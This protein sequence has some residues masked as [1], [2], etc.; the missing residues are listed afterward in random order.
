MT[1]LRIAVFYERERATPA[2]DD[3]DIAAPTL[4]DLP[5]PDTLWSISA[6]APVD[7][8][9]GVE[10][11]EPNKLTPLE[12]AIRRY[13][14]LVEVVEQFEVSSRQ[15]PREEVA[16][17]LR[18]WRTRVATA[19]ADVSRLR[20]DELDIVRRSAADETIQSVDVRWQAVTSRRAVDQTAAD[21]PPDEESTNGDVVSLWQATVAGR[22]FT[23]HVVTS[24]TL[25]R[26]EVTAVGNS[27]GLWGRAIAAVILAVLAI[28]VVRQRSI[29][30][31]VDVSIGWLYTVGLAVGGVWWLELIPSVV[32]LMIFVW[33]AISLFV[34]VAGT[35]RARRRDVGAVGDRRLTAGVNV[36]VLVRLDDGV[37][38][39]CGVFLSC[40]ADASCRPVS[41]PE[42]HCRADD[43]RSP[44]DEGRR[45]RPRWGELP[46]WRRR[47]N[48]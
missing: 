16:T 41:V 24:P 21:V 36:D 40:H 9:G 33:S 2:A 35:V 8:S 30:G 39:V 22:A 10:A 47:G 25:D 3:D 12:M 45:V 13:Q 27:T 38:A 17:A 42:R 28:M 15:R 20:G 7:L 6:V 19:R 29:L 4:L 34:L 48:I 44:R 32:G 14:A 43:S 11:R 37:C 23:A 18:P 26:L 1:P 31:R 46:P 5:M